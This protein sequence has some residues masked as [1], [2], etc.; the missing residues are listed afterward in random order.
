[1]LYLIDTNVISEAMRPNSN[2]IITQW[3]NKQFSIFVSVITE[4]IYYGLSY[5]EATGQQR[6]FEKLINNYCG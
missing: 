3:L 2:E 4:E 5:K 6:W 1:M